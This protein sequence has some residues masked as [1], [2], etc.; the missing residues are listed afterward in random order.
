[1]DKQEKFFNK[2]YLETR[3]RDIKEIRKKEIKF[4][5]EESDRTFSKTLYV[6]FYTV[7]DGNLSFKN[8]TLR[9]SDHLLKNCPH[10]QFIINPNDFLTKDKKQQF[11]RLVE[12]SIK[13]AQRRH[14]L[15]DLD[16]ITK[17][18]KNSWARGKFASF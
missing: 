7:S 10:T 1:M 4:T 5:I 13:K 17:E 2:Q 11:L 14:L 9:I 12:N 3:L 16:R 18:I 15:K 8:H 6:N